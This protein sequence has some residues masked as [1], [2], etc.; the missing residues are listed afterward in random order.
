[1]SRRPAIWGQCAAPGP[2]GLRRER[3]SAETNTDVEAEVAGRRR[4]RSA[5]DLR[6]LS[7]RRRYRGPTPNLPSRKTL[8]AAIRR[9]RL[10][11]LSPAFRP[12]GSGAERGRRLRR[13][14]AA[15]GAARA[16]GADQARARAGRRRR[17]RG[18]AEPGH[19]R[20][21]RTVSRRFADD[22]RARRQRRARRLRGRPFRRQ[23]RRSHF[24]VSRLRRGAAPS[25]R[26]S[27]LHAWRADAG[28][29]RIGRRAWPH[30]RRHSSRRRDRR[31]LLHR[32][33]HGRRDRR[34][35]DHRAQC[36]PLSGRHA[37]R[38]TVRVRGRTGALRKAYPRHPIV[39]DDVVIYAG[40]TIL[41]R[42][43]IGRGS[44]IGGG[45][46]LTHSV[47]PGSHVTQAKARH[48]TFDDGAGI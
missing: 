31:A 45:V 27:A 20:D 19:Q 7:Q 32:S 14:D 25:P 3:R 43:T 11:A 42:V 40:A 36:A 9:S 5:R 24:L 21:R 4:R 30:G 37:R 41:G 23:H 18:D 26:A 35:R 48:E 12:A 22:P 38:E 1:M 39:E 15:F 33:R 46:W 28:A 44:S 8:I 13:Q 6:R 29:H 10:G 17:R 34:N 47:A 16:A 2:K